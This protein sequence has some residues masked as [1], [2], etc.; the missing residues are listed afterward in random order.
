MSRWVYYPRQYGGVALSAMACGCTVACYDQQVGLVVCCSSTA[1][2]VG[3]LGAPLRMH[4]ILDRMKRCSLP[5]L[6]FSFVGS[7]CGAHALQCS[8]PALIDSKLEPFPTSHP[9]DPLRVW[10]MLAW[11]GLALVALVVHEL[12]PYRVG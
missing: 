11:L 2:M 12:R 9:Q 1:E 3:C 10:K 6:C 4:S 5:T 7:R 8:I